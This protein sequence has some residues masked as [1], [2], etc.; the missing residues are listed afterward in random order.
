EVAQ[1]ALP[2]G[3]ALLGW[4]DGGPHHWACLLRRSGEPAWVQLPGT[5]TNGAWDEAD[6]SLAAR[7]RAALGPSAPRGESRPLAEALARQRLGPLEGPLAG[8]KRLVVVNSPGLAGV[9]V[10]V[11]L[12]AR[13]G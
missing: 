7:L 13:P 8:V 5:A 11:L 2:D 12:A 4:L 9:P 10:E 1:A 3:T 6:R